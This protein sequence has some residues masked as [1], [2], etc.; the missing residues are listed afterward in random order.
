[1]Q[2]IIKATSRWIEMEKNLHI[3][4]TFVKFFSNI[5]TIVGSL[6]FN[7]FFRKVKLILTF[8]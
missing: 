2:K 1:M 4:H 8:N 6:T 5:Y 3:Y 7:T